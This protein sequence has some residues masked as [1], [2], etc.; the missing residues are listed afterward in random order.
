VNGEGVV[1][2]SVTIAGHSTSVSLEAAFWDALRD[3]ARRR[4]VSV[5]SL[6]GEID[7]ARGAQNLSSAI[8]VFV[9]RAAQSGGEAAEQA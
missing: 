3:L 5:Q 4:G 1:K 7:S 2:R 8:R 6:I 9:L